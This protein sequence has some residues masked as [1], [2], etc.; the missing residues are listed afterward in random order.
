MTISTGL[1]AS[2]F[3]LV[4]AFESVGREVQEA[5]LMD[6]ASIR[7]VFMHVVLPLARPALLYLVV[8]QT[9]GAVQMFAPFALMTGGG[10]AGSTTTLGYLA[11]Q[12]AFEQF[13]LGRA[14]A[15]SVLMSAIMIV[16]A[17]ALFRLMP[18]RDRS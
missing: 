7:Q 18:G 5:A 15:L 12:K 1:G 3:I 11:Y 9:I 14:S 10:P 4:A 16:L 2:I 17:I 8:V 6:G 13:D